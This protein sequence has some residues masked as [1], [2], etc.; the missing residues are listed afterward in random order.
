MASEEMRVERFPTA[1]AFL[2][3]TEPFLQEAEVENCLI[4]GVARAAETGTAAPITPYFAAVRDGDRI[5]V[6]AF[7]TVPDK[8][9]VTRARRVEALPPLADHAHASCAGFD[10][11]IGPEPTVAGFAALLAERRTGRARVRMRLRIHECRAVQRVVPEPPGRFRAAGVEDLDLLA[12]WV[13]GFLE[14]AGDRGD[15]RGIAEERIRAGTLFVWESGRL[16]SMASW[17]GKTPSGARVNLVYTPP[18]SRG[19]GYATAC[20]AALSRLLLERG[21]EYCCLYTDLDNP[22]S[23]AIYHRIGYRA[24]CDTG[25]Y[26]FA[27]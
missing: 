7:R 17:S 5:Q 13:S 4:L 1:A 18:E 20:V 2:A 10:E 26:T 11:V 6:C 3:D 25:V 9:G 8:L 23:N 21:N 22:T 14:V 27:D 12:E 19:H 24:V 16:V 15:A